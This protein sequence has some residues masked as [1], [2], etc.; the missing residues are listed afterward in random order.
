VSFGMGTASLE[1]TGVGG[2]AEGDSVMRGEDL[3]DHVLK[4]AG[5]GREPTGR[6]GRLLRRSCRKLAM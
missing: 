5:G 6:V 4:C 2:G 1:A 3:L